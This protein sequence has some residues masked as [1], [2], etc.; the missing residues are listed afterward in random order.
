MTLVFVNSLREQKFS[1]MDMLQKPQYSG[2]LT[3]W[4]FNLFFS[5]WQAF[6]MLTMRRRTSGIATGDAFAWEFEGWEHI[7]RL[8]SRGTTVCNIAECVRSWTARPPRPLRIQA[9]AIFLQIPGVP[10]TAADSTWTVC[11]SVD[12][13]RAERALLVVVGGPN[14]LGSCAFIVADDCCDWKPTSSLS[15]AMKKNLSLK[16]GGAIYAHAGLDRFK[17]DL[18][19]G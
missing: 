13:K 9:A 7:V 19:H 5:L 18:R 3:S 16:N 4:I 6:S 2:R 11:F 14:R 10:L 8:C 12:L 1:C 17:M 15:D